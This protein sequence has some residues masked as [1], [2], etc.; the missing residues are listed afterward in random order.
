[1]ENRGEETPYPQ[2]ELDVPRNI[3][4]V[5]TFPVQDVQGVFCAVVLTIVRHRHCYTLHKSL[6][7]RPP[8]PGRPQGTDHFS[9]T[10]VFTWYYIFLSLSNLS[11]IFCN[12]KVYI[13]SPRQV[14]KYQVKI[15][16]FICQRFNET[17]YIYTEFVG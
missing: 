3:N 1:M 12:L 9:Y 17:F 4:S 2:G 15:F 14:N 10:V 13:T 16:N 5:L 6:R 11:F 8:S 7:G